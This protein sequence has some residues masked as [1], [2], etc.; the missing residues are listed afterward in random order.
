MRNR[1]ALWALA[2]LFVAG[3]WAIYASLTSIAPLWPLAEFTCPIAAASIHLNFPVSLFWAAVANT[4]TY[5]LAGAV[6][7]TL[8]HLATP[9]SPTRLQ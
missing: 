3:F 5:A 1:I 9:T 4:A 2:G 8:R 7:E 6:I